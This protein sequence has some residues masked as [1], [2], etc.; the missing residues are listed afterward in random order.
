MTF[1]DKYD[2]LK[3]S[4][5]VPAVYVG[6][7]TENCERVDYTYQSKNCYFCFDCFNLENSLYCFACWGKNLVDCRL[8][9]ER[10]LCYGCIDTNRCYSSSYLSE[11]SSCRDCHFS[12][13]CISCSD[14][15]GCVGLTHKQYC[16]FNKQYTKEEY[17]KRMGE[18]KKENPEKILE[19]V[20][21]LKK[22]IP[23]PA[24]QQFNNENC[25]YGD[26]VFESK[27]SQNYL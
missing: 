11:C 13:Q 18:L 10:E 16:I 12:S 17:E 19:K 7:E 14:C 9:V 3:K 27:N 15:F 25:Q 23:H 8:A 1:L 22:K 5:P 6:P 2:L 24:S 26:H 4:I 20:F 21:E